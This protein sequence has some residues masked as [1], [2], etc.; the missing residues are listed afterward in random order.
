MSIENKKPFRV[1]AS[2]SPVSSSNQGALFSLPAPPPLARA[3]LV[4]LGAGHLG[5]RL[6]DVR[7]EL[8]APERHL[9]LLDFEDFG[10]FFFFSAVLDRE[11]FLSGLRARGRHPACV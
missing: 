4:L 5:G 6:V 2:C 9:L 1:D 8:G 10:F 7:V 3:R 11:G